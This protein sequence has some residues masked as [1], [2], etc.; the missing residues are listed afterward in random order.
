MAPPSRA[1]LAA[2]LV[3]VAA[4]ATFLVLTARLAPTGV[5]TQPGASPM[6]VGGSPLLDKPAPELAL[7]DLTGRT[8]RLA[9]YRGRPVL[10]YFWASW[11]I[12]CRTEFGLLA[13]A[14][15][16]HAQQKLQI[17]GV[18][19]KDTAEPARQ[20]MTAHDASWPAL[21]DP[22][23]AAARAYAVPGV[24]TSYYLDRAGLVRAVSYGPAPRDVLDDQLQKIL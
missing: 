20:F 23:G 24:P 5:Q 12:P 18:V 21:L 3:C 7:T 15:Q 22:D 13:D 6:V 11:C 19:Y 1:A 2:L 4:A 16:A 14:Q 17:L 9:D 10:L 8:V